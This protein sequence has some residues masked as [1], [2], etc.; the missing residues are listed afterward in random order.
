VT[1]EGRRPWAAVAIWIA[2]Q[3]TLTSLPADALPRGVNHPWDWLVHCC[4]YAAL[5]VL[6]ARAW[7]LG[8]QPPR[9]LAWLALLIS[10]FAALDEVHQLFIPGRDA[11][12]LD[13]LSD[14]VGAAAG[15]I[16]GTRLM[17]SRFAKW[18]R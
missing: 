5:G 1:G 17:F 6:I 8:G 7:A 12:V 16:V 4:I 13:W 2:I 14:T 3:L 9:R 18:L 10:V 11:E 15:L